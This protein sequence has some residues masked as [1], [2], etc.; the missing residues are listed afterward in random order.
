MRSVI[1]KV[2]TVVILALLAVVTIYPLYF[3]LITSV[4]SNQAFYTSF[5]WP[6]TR[7]QWQNYLFA[8][9]RAYMGIYLKNSLFVSAISVLLI[10]AISLMAAYGFSKLRFRGSEIVFTLLL[11]TLMVPREVTIIP[12]FILARD[13]NLLNS[14]T[15]L[16]VVYVAMQL[17]ISTYIMKNFFHQVPDE[18]IEAARID[19]CSE[20]KIL[21]RVIVPISRP[22]IGT[23]VIINFVA[24]WGEFLWAL[25]TTTDVTKRTLPIGLF[26]FQDQHG[27]DWGPFTAGVSMALIPV[28]VVYFAFQRQFI[29]GLAAGAIKG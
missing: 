29:R 5:W 13:L 15:G 8:W 1:W 19:G 26:M 27:T 20:A 2:A 14:Y 17:V 21:W 9:E 23:V 24:V 3:V 18:L 16:V 22:V 28:I 7:M 12:Q 11:A 6:T 4:K 25:I 10:S